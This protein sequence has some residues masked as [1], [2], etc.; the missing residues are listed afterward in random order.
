MQLLKHVCLFS[1]KDTPFQKTGWQRSETGRC[2]PKSGIRTC[3]Q[4][5][6][7]ECIEYMVFVQKV[8]KSLMPLYVCYNLD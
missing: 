1:E 7:S 8:Y 3:D 5:C 6:P 4:C 2:Y